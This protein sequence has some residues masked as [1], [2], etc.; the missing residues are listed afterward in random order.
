MSAR[1]LFLVLLGL[2]AIAS[3]IGWLVDPTRFYF[4]WLVSFSWLAS[5]ATG[6]LIFVAAGHVTRARWFVALRRIAEIPMSLTPLLLPLAI[7]VCIGIG[8]LYGWS[9]PLEH[10]SEGERASIEHKSAWLNPAFFVVRTSIYL[11]CWSVFA[12]R[13]GSLSLRQDREPGLER[14]PMQR[15]SALSLPILAFTLTFASFDW[16]MSLQPTWLSTVFGIYFFAGGF[17]A[18]LAAIG[19]LVWSVHRQGL[20]PEAIHSSHL[21]S[22]GKLLFTGVV[23]WAYIAFVQVLLVWI[24]NTPH[25]VPFFLV[26]SGPGWGPTS[27]VLGLVHFVIPFLL[28]LSRDL[29]RSFSSTAFFSIWLLL[30]H[31]LDMYWLVMPVHSPEGPSFHWLDPATMLVVVG[32]SG[33]FALWRL[34]G[35]PLVPERDPWLADASRY[36]GS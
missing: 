35:A 14:L 26:R 9:G 19:L 6:A 17:L 20:L 25:E 5:L 8:H 7:P 28:L 30:A 29:K 21:I 2:G 33:L 27:F 12:W 36:K 34:G 13:L 24:A 23:F 10:L 31:W 15:L 22:L 1:V 16:L 3:V 32:A 11:V 18:A 4:S